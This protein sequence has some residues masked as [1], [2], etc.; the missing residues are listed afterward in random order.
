[1]SA[2]INGEARKVSLEQFE[3]LIEVNDPSCQISRCIGR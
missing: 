2:Y 1:M 3:S